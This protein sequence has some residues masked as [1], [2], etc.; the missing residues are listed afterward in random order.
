MGIQSASATFTR[1][2]VPDPVTEDFWSYVDEKLQAGSFK[3][4]EADQAQS[5][6]FASWDDFFDP[7][8]SDVS[9]HKGEYVAFNFRVDQRKVPAVIMKQYVRQSIQKFRDEHDGRSPSRK[10]R[11]EIQE[12]MENWL[13]NQM[14]PQPSACEV[15]WSPAG[16]W[17]LLGTTSTKV[18][19][20]FLEQ[21]ENQFR[22]Y[23]VPLYHVHWALNLLPLTGREKDILSSMIPVK[24]P[25]AMEEGRFLGY[26]FLTWLWFFTEH[27]K[28]MI[29][30]SDEQ[31]AEVNL[32]ERVVLTLPGEGKERVV[33]TTQAN[34][35]HEARTAL[36]QGKLV[37]EIQLFIRIADDEYFLTL[38]SSLWGVKGL[39][40][41]KQ[42]S[43]FDKEDLEGRFLEK[44]YFMEKVSAV[45]NALYRKYL[46]QRLDPGW[47]SDVLPL[48]RQWIESKGEDVEEA[49]QAA[50]GNDG[51]GTGGE[52]AS[53]AEEKDPE[54]VPF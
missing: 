54:S 53:N 4:C 51:V 31:Q 33:C 7:S 40:T 43:E 46:G 42:L 47:E 8:F 52:P 14:L 37:Q 32:G 48:F 2:Y 30:F 45:L 1:F 11:Q 3:E 36:Q 39:K 6:G 25:T 27:E 23:P 15:V 18:V 34:S 28:G 12:N 49:Y 22:I 17:M 5:V 24:S 29:K 10:E 13:L 26:E 20:T 44:M 16:K 41:P 50:T 21:F 38:D 9:Y 19:E 35:L